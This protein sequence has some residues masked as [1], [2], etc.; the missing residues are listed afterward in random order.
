MAPGDVFFGWEG[1]ISRRLFVGCAGAMLVTGLAVQVTL[2]GLVPR[3]LSPGATI[4]TAVIG[5]FLLFSSTL[6]AMGALVVKRRH[7]LGLCGRGI[8]LCFLLPSL[9][10]ALCSVLPTFGLGGDFASG[11]KTACILVVAWWLAPLVF[12]DGMAGENVFGAD[13]EPDDWARSSV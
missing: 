3:V 13:P 2:T 1:R 9:G 10:A 11:L 6:M 8:G 5:Q 7:D 12:Q 4:M